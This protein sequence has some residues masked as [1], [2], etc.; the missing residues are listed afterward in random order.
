MITVTVDKTSLFLAKKSFRVRFIIYR[1]RKNE[2]IAIETEHENKIDK[3]FCRSENSTWLTVDNLF[4][5]ADRV[6]QCN[7]KSTF[8]LPDLCGSIVAEVSFGGAKRNLSFNQSFN[9]TE[10]AVVGFINFVDEILKW[11]PVEKESIGFV[12]SYK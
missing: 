5:F 7:V 11:K 12:F 3:L 6:T 10:E 2:Y 1:D 4:N 8:L 9:T